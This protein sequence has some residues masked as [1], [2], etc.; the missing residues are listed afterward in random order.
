M[1][2]KLNRFESKKTPEKRDDVAPD[3]C[4]VKVLLGLSRG[5]MALFELGANEQSRA[6]AHRT[7]E[8][9]W[10]FLKGRGEMWRQLDKYEEIVQVEEGTCVTIP[11]G[12]KFQIRSLGPENLLALGVTMP[13]WPGPN[14]WYEVKGKWE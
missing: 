6:G 10:Y 3:G 7:I 8:E 14:E 5:G 11:T 1:K 2:I 4:D 13:P 12:T 9:I